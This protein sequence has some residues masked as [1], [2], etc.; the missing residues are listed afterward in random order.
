MKR[1]LTALFLVPF[2]VYTVLFAPWWFFH[3]VI[4][5]VSLL[6]F[7][8]YAT[9]TGSFAPLG[10]IAGLLLLFAPLPFAFLIVVLSVFA[11]MCVPVLTGNTRAAALAMG[12]VYIFGAWKTA[13][14]IRESA[15]GRHWLM[16]GLMVNWI[17][18]TGAY[19]V[20][21][22]FGRHKLAPS[23]SPGKSWEGALASM[24]TGMLFGIL[25]LPLV[26]H[27]VSVATAALFALLG[28]AAGQIGD[29]AESAVKR[30]GGVK[31][32]G[33]L[34][35]GHGG[36]LDRVDSTLFTMPV[37]YGLLLALG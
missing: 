21:R 7:H 32:S 16:F 20:G 2:A 34:L 1:V 37:V 18:D 3:L 23:I 12:I 33:T 19:Y 14:L 25:Y 6:C 24:V 28:N 29:L 11:A 9:I 35:P 17:G 8:E 10:Y 13:M 4:A 22:R 27:G 15:G 36:V 26:L 5:A 31:D 30:S